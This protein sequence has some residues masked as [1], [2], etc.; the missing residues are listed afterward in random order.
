MCVCVCVCVC[1]VCLWL[2]AR[3]KGHRGET[4]EGEL[5]GGR[6]G[7]A[8]VPKAIPTQTDT[9]LKLANGLHSVACCPICGPLFSRWYTD[10]SSEGTSPLRRGQSGGL[11]NPPAPPAL[12]WNGSALIYL[13]HVLHSSHNTVNYLRGQGSSLRQ[14][15]GKGHKTRDLYDI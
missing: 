1:E 7:V 9:I 6:G 3:S 15:E 10:A 11:L 5:R 14:G 2:S 4:G 13:Q 12:K 8:T